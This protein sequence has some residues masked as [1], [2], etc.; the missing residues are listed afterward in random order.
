MSRAKWKGP[1][2]H[3]KFLKKNILN[4]SNINVWSRASAIPSVFIGQKFLIHSG[5]DFKKLYITRDK[6]GYK[7]GEFCTTR[8]KCVHKNKI[9][10]QKKTRK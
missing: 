3:F 8:H 9:K 2:I 7:F 6:V 5:N 1:F 4:T 10:I